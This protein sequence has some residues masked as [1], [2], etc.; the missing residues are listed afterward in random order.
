MAIIKQGILGGL[1][2]K[3]GSVVG[4]SWKGR[5]ILKALPLSVANP[6]TEGQVQQ[7]TSFSLI[8]ILASVLLTIIVRPVYNPISGNI[9]GSNLFTSQN[10]LFYDGA[11]VFDPANAFIGGGTNPSEV[12]ND[13]SFNAGPEDITILWNDSTPGGS[14]RKTDKAHA[15]LL[16]PLSGAVYAAG[17]LNERQDDQT[18]LALVS[19]VKP[20]A[21]MKT[22]WV[23][24]AFVAADGRT[25][26]VKISP[27]SLPV[28][29][30]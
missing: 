11:G 24:L 10:K 29:F 5:A 2:G 1:S 9:T 16:E 13:A 21:G 25:V 6:R 28:T 15:F 30:A 19:G 4:T 7:R 20:A 8:S 23:F 12:A 22:C 18:E 17:G 27:V 14:I 26:S 3:I